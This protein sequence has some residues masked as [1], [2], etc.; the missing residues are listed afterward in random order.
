MG[1]VM[2]GV[3]AVR[4]VEVADA[5]QPHPIAPAVSHRPPHRPGHRLLPGT[6]RVADVRRVLLEARASVEVALRPA[7]PWSSP[8]PLG[9]AAPRPAR[10]EQR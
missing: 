6:E 2:R 7:L 10:I 1:V 3:I 4:V 5:V 8:P 9:P